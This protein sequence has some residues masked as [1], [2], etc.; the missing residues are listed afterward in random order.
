MEAPPQFPGAPKKSKTGLI[1]FGTIMA[2]L[3]CCCGI[4][5]VGAYLLKDKAKGFLKSSFGMVGCSI[6]MSQQRDALLTYAAKHNGT[7]PAAKVWQDSIAPYVVRDK[8]FDKPDQPFSVPT[9]KD[10]SCDPSANTA[11]TFNVALSGKKLDSVKDQMGTVAL[12]ESAGRGRNKAAEWKEPPF[13]QSPKLLASAP[14]GWIR[15]GLKGEVTIK[16]QRGVVKPIPRVNASG[17][18]NVDVDSSDSK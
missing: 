2:V 13:D 7:L 17:G 5:G 12:F 9:V 11:V 14:R 6:T 16:D 8:E 1:I 10:D 15:Q 4:C 3:V 18:L